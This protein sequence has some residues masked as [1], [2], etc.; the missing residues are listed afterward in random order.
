MKRTLIIALLLVGYCALTNSAFAQLSGTY[1][2]VNKSGTTIKA[3]YYA[4]AGSNNWSNNISTLDKI[5]NN[6]GFQ[7]GFDADKDHCN[8]DLKYVDA[9]GKDWTVNNISLCTASVITLLK[10]K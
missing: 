1:T 9:D 5:G 4:P 2:V 7:Y 3:V 8:I 6:E 10:H